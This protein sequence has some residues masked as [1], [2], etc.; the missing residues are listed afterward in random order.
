MAAGGVQTAAVG[1]GA[2]AQKSR[3]CRTK[4]SRRKH[5]KLRRG[6]SAGRAQARGEGGNGRARDDAHQVTVKFA[7]ASQPT[8]RSL[9]GLAR[10]A[11]ARQGAPASAAAEQL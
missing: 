9:D 10:T 6:S 1:I 5:L 4:S 7:T 11:D 2:E 3:S 8:T